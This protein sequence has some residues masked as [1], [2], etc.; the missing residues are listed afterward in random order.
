S[1]SES[2]HWINAFGLI[3]ADD[4]TPKQIQELKERGI[5][6]TN[7]Y[8]VESLYYNL[9]IIKFVSEKYGELTGT[10]SEDLYN[11]A[12]A[13]IVSDINS[14]KERLCSRL[15]EKRVRTVIM[16]M[17]PKHTDIIKKEG[18]EIK[19][20]LENYYNQEEAI[21]NQLIADENLNGLIERYPIRETPVLNNI[22]KGLGIDRATYE[23]I[24]RKLIIDNPDVLSVFRK[25]LTELTTLVIKE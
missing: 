10:N 19:L 7:C 5:I 3:D 18:F 13:K 11:K 21:F 14:H 12:T 16:S 15:S 20:D 6:A 8:S 2:L 1:S 17:L 4:R 9:N 24:V 23:N 22:A 25:L